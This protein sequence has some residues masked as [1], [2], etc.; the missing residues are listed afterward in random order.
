V[1][2]KHPSTFFTD[3]DAS[4][5][6]AIAYVFSNTCHHICLWHIYLKAAKHLN[7]VIHNH[8]KSFKLIL[9]VVSM[10]ID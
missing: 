6:R 3:Q 1:G 8:P 4:M 9:K 2:G 7:H 10:K 5:T